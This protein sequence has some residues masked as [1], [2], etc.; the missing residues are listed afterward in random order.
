[1]KTEASD[2]DLQIIR[3]KAI[4]QAA[5]KAGS[6]RQLAKLLG[7]TKGALTHWKRLGAV[8]PAPHCPIIEKLTEHEVPCEKLNHEVDWG[9]L[10][11]TPTLVA[12]AISITQ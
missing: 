2:L 8:V 9:Y 12:P 5:K 6:A 10:R 7:I 4:D 1:M 11:N 3:I